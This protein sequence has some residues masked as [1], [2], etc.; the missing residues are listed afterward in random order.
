MSRISS[1]KII[2]S[3]LNIGIELLTYPI[4]LLRFSAVVVVPET[5]KKVCCHSLRYFNMRAENCTLYIA[6]E[7]RRKTWAHS[8]SRILC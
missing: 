8:T 6:S 5:A 4:H 3:Q 2:R 7:F 1:I